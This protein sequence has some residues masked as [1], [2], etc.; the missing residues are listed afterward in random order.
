M[1]RMHKMTYPALPLPREEDLLAVSIS[2]LR[3]TAGAVISAWL[4]FPCLSQIG[5]CKLWRCG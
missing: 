3:M 4:T 1:Y 5:I 2:E